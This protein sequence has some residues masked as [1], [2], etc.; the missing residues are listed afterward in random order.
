MLSGW[1]AELTAKPAARIANRT[2]SDLLD[3]WLEP[4]RAKQGKIGSQPP[5]RRTAAS[6]IPRN[7]AVVS[8]STI[9]VPDQV[10]RLGLGRR[11]RASASHSRA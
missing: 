10:V 7:S 9:R 1:A 5:W 3:V 6:G 11:I 2:V 4:H 8:S